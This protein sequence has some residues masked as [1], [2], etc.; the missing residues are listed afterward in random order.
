MTM[1]L[2]TRGIFQTGPRPLLMGLVETGAV[3]FATK[4]GP[5]F[6]PS[7]VHVYFQSTQ[8]LDTWNHVLSS[9]PRDGPMRER[10]LQLLREVVLGKGGDAVQ[11]DS[12]P[13]QFEEVRR[14]WHKWEEHE[15]SNRCRKDATPPTISCNPSTPSHSP[16]TPKAKKAKARRLGF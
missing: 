4:V 6:L 9:L 15:Q 7:E 5:L 10:G 12:C 11:G 14:L 13:S 1:C 2:W 3:V 8:L 16:A